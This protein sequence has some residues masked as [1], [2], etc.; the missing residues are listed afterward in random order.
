MAKRFEKKK[1]NKKELKDTEKKAG[2]VRKAAY[3]VGT[4][5]VAGIG[6]AAKKIGPVAVNAAKKAGPVALNA[7]KT[8]IKL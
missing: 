2:I 3:A 1:L 8:I 7:A 5:S 6:M 4:V